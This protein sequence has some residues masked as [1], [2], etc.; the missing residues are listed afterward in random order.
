MATD[1]ICGMFVEE[2]GAELKLVRENRTYY[3]CSAH[4]LEE[5]AQP[6]VELKRLRSRLAVAWTF[7]ILTVAFTYVLRGPY[8]AGL[9]GASAAVVQFYPGLAFYRSTLDAVRSRHWNMDVLIAV[10]TTVAFAYSA[11]SLLWP[12]R[13][14]SATYFDASALIVTLILTGSYLEHFTRERARGALRK[15]SE[16]RP[17]TALVLRDGVEVERPVAEVQV[18]D[19][20]RVRPGGRFPADGRILDGRST[21]AEALV[22]GE[23]LPVAKAPGDKVIAGTVNGE[24]VLTV[25]AE[26]VGED[27]LLAQIGGLV[28]EAETSRVPLQALADRIASIFA[29]FVLALALVT[30]IAWTLLGAGFA[31]AVLV[32]V[33][34]V[35]TA[36]PCAFGLAT[37]AAIVVGTGRAAEA[38]I[39][40]K[41]RDSLERASRIDLVVTDKT[42]T[43]T[44]GRPE[45]DEVVPA[46][47]GDRKA[48]LALAAGI[49]A[50]SEHPLAAAVR[51]EARAQGISPARVEGAE[52]E[53]GAGVR[54]TRN[55]RRVAVLSGTAIRASGVALGALAEP[56][57][58]FESTGAAWSAVVEDDRPL[59]ILA[60]R[61][62]VAP[63]VAEGIRALRADGLDV[64]LATGDH[65]VSAARVAREVGITRVLSGLRP[66]E[67]LELLRRLQSEGHRVAYVGDGINDA[68]ALAAADLGIAIGSGTEVAKESGGVILVRP[69]FGGVAVALR[70]GRRTV[71]KV[72]GNLAWAVGYNAVLLPIAAGALVPLFGLG[73]FG[74]LPITGA[75]AMGLSS[76][77]V[78]LNS[79]SLRRV[80]LR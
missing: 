58:R 61:D 69:D 13:L 64:I 46:P 32:F 10:G 26:R 40:F 53:P 24:G 33:S 30:T 38:G 65:E 16:L 42:G 28:T 31:V 39:L 55:G 50:G 12:G 54:A 27:T 21:V 52:A 2:A 49:E 68:P 23:G 17:S 47:G 37:P 76:T 63:G 14:L 74:V 36:C 3:F 78:V 43:L 11:A 29:P 18:G 62:T 20:L 45:L 71:E 8:G 51:E 70:I 72:R 1:P 57:A 9:A 15:L 80:A 79:L 5:F 59:G 35:I 77:T 75:L 60:F 41:G 6:E 66:A 48:L 67:K 19:R 56:V 25:E 44:V 73:V 22:T 7:S 4:C 34:V